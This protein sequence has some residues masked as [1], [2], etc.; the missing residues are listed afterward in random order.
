MKTHDS[1]GPIP[2]TPPPQTGEATP[3]TPTDA[4]NTGDVDKFTTLMNRTDAAEGNSK[5]AKQA[6]TQDTE[7]SNKSST[8]MSRTGIAEGRK[9]LAK[10]ADTSTAADGGTSAT[11]A[12]RENSGDARAKSARG[13][14]LSNEADREIHGTQ[15]ENESLG[16]AILQSMQKSGAP[17][18]SAGLHHTTE[19][20]GDKVN[21]ISS[22]IAGRILVSD[23]GK[24]GEQEV[25]IQI[26]ESVLPGTEVRISREAGEVKIQFVTTSDASLSLLVANTADLQ[27]RLQDRLRGEQI[28]VDIQNS[29]GEQ[30][31]QQGRSRQRRNLYE[32]T[33]D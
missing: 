6:V 17:L 5:S 22:Q 16:A 32:E 25:R 13:P 7:A 27:H 12:G 21:D 15:F 29:A 8:L 10:Q 3:A 2:G 31:D 26:K 24:S 9:V 14:G 11:G 18:P 4:P 20:V 19:N 1:Q 30:P 23:S 28:S 33:Q